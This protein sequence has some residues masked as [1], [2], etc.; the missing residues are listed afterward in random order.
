MSDEILGY[1]IG[2]LSIQPGDILV[3]KYQGRVRA[4]TASFIKERCQA[5]M[6][7]IPVMVIGDDIDIAILTKAEINGRIETGREP[8]KRIIDLPAA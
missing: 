7:D 4:E 3:V 6:G 1:S 5:C 8:P 2:R